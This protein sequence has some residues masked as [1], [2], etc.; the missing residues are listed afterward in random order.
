[1]ACTIKLILNILFQY[2]IAL[3][4][5]AELKFCFYD[6]YLNDFISYFVLCL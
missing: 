1:M 4:D 3:D 2:V 6:F 5:H